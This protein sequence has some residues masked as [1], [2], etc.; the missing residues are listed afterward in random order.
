MQ[1]GRSI[2]IIQN[3]GGESFGYAQEGLVYPNGSANMRAIAKSTLMKFWSQPERANSKGALQSGYAEAI[4]ASR[5]TPQEI[6]GQYWNCMAKIRWNGCT[7]REKDKHLRAVV[8]RETYRYA[9]L[10][11]FKN[12][13]GL[14]C[15]ISNGAP[16]SCLT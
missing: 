8:R 1:Q 9:D 5:E 16:P 15:N 3:G 10:S 12:L 4:K 7:K 2:G 13:E 6:E 14:T 11:G